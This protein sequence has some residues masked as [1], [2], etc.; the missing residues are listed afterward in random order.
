MTQ[1]PTAT[2][3]LD[4]E[5]FFGD[6]SARWF[7]VAARNQVEVAL[8]TGATRICV[9]MPTGSGK[10]VTSGL[11]FSSNRI[12]QSLGVKQG[13]PLKLLFVAHK[14]RLL[15]QAE[16]TYIQAENIELI[17][18]SAFSELPADLEWHITC[19][20]ECHHEAMSSIQYHLEKLGDKPVIGLTATPDR[21]DGCV[22]KFDVIVNPISREQAVAEGWL[23]ATHIHSFVDVPSTSKTA[24]LTDILSNYAHQMGNTMIF[25][26]TKKEVIALTVVLKSLGYVAVGILDQKEKELDEVLNKFSAGEVQFLVNCNRISEGVDVSGCTDVLL[27][28][29]VGSYTML[30]QIIGRAARPDS[31][32]NVWELINPLSATNLDTTVV[33]GTPETHRLVYKQKGE[34]MEQNFDYT[35][36]RTN[37]QLGISSG[38]RVHH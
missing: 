3:D 28:R 16:Q 23:A 7:Q 20:D 2:A 1:I 4:I 15:T 30:N 11:I 6:K 17:V 25:V 37:K 10:T 21:A 18:Q 31:D 12:R 13:E 38:L 19:I 5:E 33:V 27:G 8:E 22:I 32:C 36:R 9:V 14:H 26:K 35:S 24:T 29:Q 34:W